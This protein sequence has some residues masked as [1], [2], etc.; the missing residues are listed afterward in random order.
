MCEVDLTQK[1]LTTSHDAEMVECTPPH[2][3]KTD[4]SKHS[5]FPSGTQVSQCI[6][7]HLTT[8]YTSTTSTCPKIVLL[9][10]QDKEL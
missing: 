9:H 4:V 2:L 10:D 5:N 7:E 6:H 1:K 8:Q 3:L